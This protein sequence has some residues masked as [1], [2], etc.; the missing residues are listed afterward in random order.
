MTHIEFAQVIK[1]RPAI[2]VIA[3]FCA[4]AT[5]S[6]ADPISSKVK[7][8]VVVPAELA[9]FEKLR[10]EI[11]LWE[12]DPRLADVK[13][14]LFDELVVK[15]YAHKNGKETRTVFSLG[16]KVNGGKTNAGKAYYLTVFVTQG[17]QRTHIGEK[18]GKPGMT[19]V[20]TD[21]NPNDVTLALRAIGQQKVAQK[22]PVKPS[23]MWSG[24][25]E[26]EKLAKDAPAVVTSSKA[27]AKLWKDWKLTDKMPEVDFKKE[28]V[29]VTT[30]RGS[31]LTLALTLDERGDL[32]VGGLA[33][34]DLRPGFRYIIATVSSAGV[35]T[36]NGKEMA[37]Q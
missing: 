4:A 13:A 19:K 14:S 37:K 23:K 31:K 22:K 9:S 2:A 8:S 34:R 15:D 12:Y 3:I 1:M 7:G 29:V 16:E 11:Q 30:S 27:L 35:R 28:L 5:T 36:V 6:A 18:D 26:D 33:T 24:S 20:L 25:V 17:D 32:R 21:G 10:L